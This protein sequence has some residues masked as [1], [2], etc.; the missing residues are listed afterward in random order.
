MKI[1]RR[2]EVCKLCEHFKENKQWALKCG[3]MLLTKPKKV[4][5]C[6]RIAFKR[7][8]M[9]LLEMV[10]KEEKWG[11]FDVPDDCEYKLEHVLDEWCDGKQ[12]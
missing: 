1:K 6:D 5:Y 7:D 4:N 10:D 9:R 3:G 12:A 11:E 8:G 2:I